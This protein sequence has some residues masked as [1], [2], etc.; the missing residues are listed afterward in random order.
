MAVPIER[1]LLLSIRSGVF[2]VLLTPLVVTSSTLFP[3]VIGKAIYARVIIEGVF[4]LWIILSIRSPAH[5]LPHS[6]V[7]WLFGMYLFAGLVAA[8]VGVSFN[9]SFWGDYRRMGG[10]F[11]LAHWFA[12]TVVL[13]S[14]F[15][16]ANHW[17]WLLNANL[18]VSLLIALLGL[19]QHY[20][21]RIFD[22]LFWYLQPT[23]RV[24][25]TFGNP[26]FV[27]AY[28]LVNV[29]VALA[30]LAHSFEMTSQPERSRHPLRRQARRQRQRRRPQERQ[31]SV[32]VPLW[33]GF[34][35]LTAGLDLWVLTL[36]GTRGA[37]A[38]LLVG[39]LITG[40][41]Y[42]AWGNRRRL[43]LAAGAL[44]ATLLLLVLAAPL[45]QNTAIV[46][47]LAE[48]NVL[49][50]R[51]HDAVSGGF[52]TYKPRLTVAKT[53]LEAF[54]HATILGWGPENFAVAFDRYVDILDTPTQSRLADQAHNKPVEELVTKG[55]VGFSLYI[56]ILGRM[57]WVL[58]LTARREPNE[59]L[60][61][62]FI[63]AALTGY[64]VQNLFLFDTPG[65]LL[66]FILLL[67]WVGGKEALGKTVPL[68][69]DTETSP[70]S[71]ERTRS[72]AADSGG[73]A[74]SRKR[75]RAA[76]LS[77]GVW[78]G[79]TWFRAWLVSAGTLRT[80]VIV[81][82][83]LLVVALTAVSIYFLNY[84]PFRAAQILPVQ[85]TSMEQFFTDAQ[86][87]FKTFP[88]MTVLG[89]QIL[90]DT[91]YE[92]W[93]LV[94]QDA[95]PLFLSQVQIEGQ[96]AIELEPHNARLHIGLARLY[97][98]ASASN[99]GF[100]PIAR[101]HVEAAQSLAPRLFDTVKVAFDQEIAEIN[102]PEALTL[103]Y[104]YT[105]SGP[106][107][108]PLLA[109]LEKEAQRG[110]IDQ[111]G[112][113]E[114]FCR[115]AGEERLSVAERAQIQCE[116]D[117]YQPVLDVL[118]PT[119]V[120]LPLVDVGT[121]DFAVSF[122]AVGAI[123]AIF[124]WGGL[125]FDTAPTSQGS[126]PVVT[127]NGIDEQADSPDAAYWSRAGETFS[128]GAWVNLVDGTSSS[129]LSKYDGTGDTREWIFGLQGTDSLTLDLYD[130]SWST[131]PNIATVGD[132][133]IAQNVWVF[134]VATYDGTVNASGLNLYQDRM[135]IAG[136]DDDD[137]AFVAIR[138]LGGTVKLGHI[139]VP[140]A[141]LFDGKI[142]GGPC[143]PFFTHKEL[144]VTN[145]AKLYDYCI[146]LLS[147]P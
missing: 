127:L 139:N 24:D 48:S 78:S 92:H 87:S 113:I 83:A 21:A 94:G 37:A 56:F 124:T 71:P 11:D 5:R 128:V 32:P 126:V 54:T 60:F 14:V 9:R 25:V 137:V 50:R 20:D 8:L 109:P 67:A 120:I 6:W 122:Q 1:V 4:G 101:R 107:L 66:P 147:L 15:I 53:G 95:E 117:Y 111:I 44:T 10:V 115:W 27:G 82:A 103:V 80:P 45:V 41:A 131:N 96:A 64:V 23:G 62:I 76:T 28:M 141:Q 31:F 134:V 118:G 135:V 90:V 133:A 7:I 102:Y 69:L 74:P 91:L 93:D 98:R 97:Q 108:N 142:A 52:D 86:L 89:R 104:S 112:L 138:D 39:L 106:S 130:A 140:P 110:L 40:V 116:P 42:L 35:T 30:F 123:P 143:G 79:L 17:R 100:L 145:V 26:T 132:A 46:K 51:L 47:T 63:G 68:P 16:R 57:A 125:P 38:G 33:R 81:S 29:F 65:T 18:G 58:A 22:A 61:A 119:G 121:S 43:K 85:S 105:S 129:I 70:G 72:A 77:T 34:W 144:S 19:A 136:S 49:A 55:I 99:P 13:V 146:G 73:L 88:P 75:R 114:Y 84:R 36:S 59:Q 2:V 3:Y 12:F